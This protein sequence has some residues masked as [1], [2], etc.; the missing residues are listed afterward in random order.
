MT[1]SGPLNLR[2]YL[3]E[4][5]LAPESKNNGYSIEGAQYYR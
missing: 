1:I 2:D 4:N 3:R 5:E